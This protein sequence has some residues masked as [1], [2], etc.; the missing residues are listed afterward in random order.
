MEEMNM[1]KLILTIALAITSVIG[2]N[3]QTKQDNTEFYAGYQFLRTNVET[4]TPSFTF[5]RETDSH[6]FNVSATEYVSKNAGFTA[7]LGANF[8]GNGRNIYTIQG[9]LT[10]KG[11]RKGKVQPFARALGGAYVAQNQ[12]FNSRRTK[13]DFAYTLGVGLDVKFN[14]VGWR[15]IQ[16]DYLGTRNYNQFDNNVRVGTGFFF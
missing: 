8:D 10:V 14:K 15:I 12:T 13:S 4:R 5:N 6:G 16:V 3:A 11:N 1:K 9:G 2:I 7:E